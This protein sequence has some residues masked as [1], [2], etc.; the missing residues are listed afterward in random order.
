LQAGDENQFQDP[1]CGDGAANFRHGFS[2]K[3]LAQATEFAKLLSGQDGHLMVS[4]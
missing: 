4:I 3:V 2:R 1:D